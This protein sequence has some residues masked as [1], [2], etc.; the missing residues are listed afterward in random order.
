M[1]SNF[2]TRKNGYKQ[3]SKSELHKLI[4]AKK[5]IKRLLIL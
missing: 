3:T 4:K 1:K 5:L 2:L